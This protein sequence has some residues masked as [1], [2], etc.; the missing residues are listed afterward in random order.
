MSKEEKI[1]II[2]ELLEKIVIKN[3]IYM[4]INPN[5]KIIDI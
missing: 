5:Y 1:L 3:D 2:N 4:P